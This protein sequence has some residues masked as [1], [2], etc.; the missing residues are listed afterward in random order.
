M[1]AAI[2]AM[3]YVTSKRADV[4]QWRGS[5]DLGVRSRHVVD[6]FAARLIPQGKRLTCPPHSKKTQVSQPLGFDTDQAIGFGWGAFR[7]L[8]GGKREEASACSGGGQGAHPTHAGII[9]PVSK[10]ILL[11]A[12]LVSRSSLRRAETRRDLVERMRIRAAVP[13]SPGDVPIA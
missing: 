8:S 2:T 12:V 5:A 4:F 1:F 9:L 3:V 7:P 11:A 6:R 10:T 13:A